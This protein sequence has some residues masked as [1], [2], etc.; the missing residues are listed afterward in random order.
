LVCFSDIFELASREKMAG[1]F[2]VEQTGYGDWLVTHLVDRPV[3][4]YHSVPRTK[5]AT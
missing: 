4:P 2:E 1:L 3:N 5:G